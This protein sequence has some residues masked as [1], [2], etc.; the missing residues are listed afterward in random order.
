MEQS[1]NDAAFLAYEAI[2]PIY[3][4]FCA[5][6]DYEMW[7]GVLLSALSKHGLE[8]G[9][10]LDIGCGTGRALS[11][12]FGGAGKLSVA[13]SRR[14]CLPRQERN[15]VIRFASTRRTLTAFRALRARVGIE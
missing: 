14:R 5:A 4:E 11:R 15:S 6:N 2:A 8:Q 3:D 10:L 1:P 13:T 12:C 9:R 7:T